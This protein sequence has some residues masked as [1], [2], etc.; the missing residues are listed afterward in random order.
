MSE[1]EKDAGMERWV[2]REG[3]T[4]FEVTAYLAADF[5]E[6]WQRE[7]LRRGV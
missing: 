3:E 4:T 2:A 7:V 6:A 5:D 1:N